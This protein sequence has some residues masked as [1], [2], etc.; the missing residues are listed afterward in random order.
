MYF[1]FLQLQTRRVDERCSATLRREM[2]FFSNVADI[3]PSCIRWDAF[4][5]SRSDRSYRM[6][7]SICQLVIE[8][9]MLTTSEGEHRLAKYIDD[10]HLHRLYERFVLN[11][12]DQEHPELRASAPQIPWVIDDGES[13]ML[14]T[15]WSDITLMPRDDPS[16]VLIID[17]K[18]YNHSTQGRYETRTVHSANLYQ[19]FTYVKNREAGFGDM[20]HEVGG[21]LLYARTNEAVQPDQS[22]MMSGNRIEVRTLDL[23][24]EFAGIAARLDGIAE[25]HFGWKESA[26]R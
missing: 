20:R 4:R 12:Y 16:R 15:M 14:P 9:M 22:Y 5:F 17:A 1:I 2:L 26:F 18:F 21:M 19:I 3:N 6:L 25:E 23:S 11:Y 7:I 8:G 13:T 24:A 10:Q